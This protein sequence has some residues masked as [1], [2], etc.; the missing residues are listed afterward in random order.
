[1]DKYFLK[2]YH[3]QEAQNK[4][5]KSDILQTTYFSFIKTILRISYGM[6]LYKS[7]N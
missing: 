7:D 6:I 4:E 5:K 1:M 2:Y 3:E